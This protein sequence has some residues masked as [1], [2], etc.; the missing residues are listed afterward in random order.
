MKSNIEN[1]WTKNITIIEEIKDTDLM[2]DAWLKIN[3][4]IKWI[5]EH[6]RRNT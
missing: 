4:I 5:N 1:E 6:E 2:T 3:E